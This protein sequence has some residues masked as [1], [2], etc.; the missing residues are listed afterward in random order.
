MATV[1][2]TDYYANLDNWPGDL[3]A[4]SDGVTI[5]LRTATSFSYTYAAGTLFAGFTVTS[6]GTGFAYD[7]TTPIGGSMTGLKITD[8]AGHVVLTVTNIAAGSL[9]SDF[10]LFASYEFGWTDPGGGG[11]GAQNKNAWSQLLSGNDI[12]NGTAGDDRE[13]IVGVN[14]GN[15][16]FNMGAG[17]DYVN[18]GMGNDTINGGDGWDTLSFDQTH[19]NEGIPMVRGITVN[20]AAGTV[21]D[22]YGYTDKITG[23][24]EIRGSATADKF[25][26]GATGMD[27]KGLRG[28]DTIIAGSS[29]D[30]W[31]IYNDDTWKGGNRGIVAN[32]QTAIA[33]TTITGTIRD[34]FGNLDHTT[35]VHNVAGTRY[36]DIFR[37][38]SQDDVFAGG[39]GK[40]SYVGGTGVDAL[41]FNWWFSDADH[42]GIIVNLKLATGQ[43]VDDGF[44][45]S[46]NATQIEEVW[47]T[48]EA[49]RI[50]GNTFA[51]TISGKDGNDTLTGGGGHD[52][53]RWER[54]T[55][56]NGVD[57]ITD[58]G[59]AA[60]GVELDILEFNMTNMG[61]ST[62]LTLVNGTAATAAVSTF[63]Y[64]VANHMLSW[65]ADGTGAQAAIQVA[66]LNNVGTLSAANFDLF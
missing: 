13:S 38:S 28:S 30:D 37:G 34:G 19:F 61:A 36:A 57:L 9:A 50:A 25:I 4:A 5:G 49:D 63:I 22:P 1:T 27:F 39:E 14:A 17:D 10:T 40:D 16:V 35:N 65:D 7:S 3:F 59:G 55:D 29:G 48:W 24:E 20:V 54:Q 26:G 62:T 32:L 8:A 64:S 45:N 46:E 51:N 52:N 33:G 11:T 66:T 43:V 6:F 12:F 15:D 42:H 31:A 41:I 18:G 58:F 60:A 2:L 23:I 56:L 53:F 21:L 47:G 44:G